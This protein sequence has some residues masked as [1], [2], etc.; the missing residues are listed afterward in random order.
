MKLLFDLQPLAVCKHLVRSMGPR[1]TIKADAGRYSEL[2]P[3]GPGDRR[4]LALGGQRGTEAEWDLTSLLMEGLTACGESVL[5]T[6]PVSQ[7]HL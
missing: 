7:G 4:S 6:R 3:L 1:R 2:G 5:G